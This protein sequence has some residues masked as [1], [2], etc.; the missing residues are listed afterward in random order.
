MK[1]FKGTKKPLHPVDYAGRISIQDGPYYEDRDV[2]LYAETWQ[3]DAVSKSEAEANARLFCAAPELLFSLQN[4]I[5][6]IEGLPPLTAIAG[7]LEKEYKQAEL[8]I[9]KA[10]EE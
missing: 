10:L 1:E 5:K 8:A 6:G 9:N 3:G 4:L 7:A 2:L